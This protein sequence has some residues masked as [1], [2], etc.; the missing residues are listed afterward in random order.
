MVKRGTY[1]LR[2]FTGEHPDGLDGQFLHLALRD[3]QKDPAKV[4]LQ[5][6]HGSGETK[7]RTYG[8]LDGLYRNSSIVCWRLV[9][10]LDGRHD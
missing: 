1:L 4:S 10:S 6:R 5:V 7:K 3:Q 9:W 2:E 8:T